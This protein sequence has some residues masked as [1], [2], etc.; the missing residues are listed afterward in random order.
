MGVGVVMGG[1]EE[2]EKSDS[3]DMTDGKSRKGPGT[4]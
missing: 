4:G 2:E 3:E 1:A